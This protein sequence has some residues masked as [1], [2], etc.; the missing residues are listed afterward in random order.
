MV[1]KE[2]WILKLLKKY[3]SQ[4]INYVGKILKNVEK[5]KEIVQDVFCIL[6]T[7]DE[8]QIQSHEKAWLFTVSRNKAIDLLRKEKR[9]SDHRQD[10]PF[11]EDP[12]LLNEKKQSHQEIIKQIEKLPSKQQEV[13]NLKFQNDFSYK[14]ISQITGLSVSNVGYLIHTGLTSLKGGFHE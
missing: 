13:L 5:A 14:E 1:N 11:E 4:L 6:W 10:I 7:R 8:S 9:M 3:E 2:D 12:N